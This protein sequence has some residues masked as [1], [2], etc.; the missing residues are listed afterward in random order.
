MNDAGAAPAPAHYE[1]TQLPQLQ[2]SSKFD[3]TQL[4]P[5]CSSAEIWQDPARSSQGPSLPGDKI[6]RGRLPPAR[7][8]LASWLID[9][10][11]FWK[12]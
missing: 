1:A 12:N 11:K 3:R 6:W 9:V 10:E 8:D 2:L 4:R 5:G 7:N